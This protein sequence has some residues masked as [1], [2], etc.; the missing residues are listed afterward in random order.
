MLFHVI[1]CDLVQHTGLHFP[2]CHICYSMLLSGCVACL[3]LCLHFSV[4]AAQRRPP[5]HWKDSKR[6]VPAQS[7]TDTSPP[8]APPQLPPQVV[9]PDGSAST[10]NTPSQLA[11]P[12]PLVSATSSPTTDSPPFAVPPTTTVVPPGPL[13]A[14]AEARRAVHPGYGQSSPG[15]RLEDMCI[16]ECPEGGV[17]A[18]RENVPIPDVGCE[19]YPHVITKR[20]GMLCALP[21]FAKLGVVVQCGAVWCDVVRCGAVMWGRGA[22]LGAGCLVCCRTLT[23]SLSASPA[24]KQAHDPIQPSLP[25]PLLP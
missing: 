1:S 25:P 10:A 9:Q 18:A 12:I 4:V 21:C 23:F 15:P 2:F 19:A 20:G 8:A 6:A 13:V 16:F 14:H 22:L 7:K 3:V 11:T 5:Y 17:A 24:L